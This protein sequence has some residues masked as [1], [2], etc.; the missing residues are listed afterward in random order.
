MSGR[1]FFPNAVTLE[2]HKY[3]RFSLHAAITNEHHQAFT[4]TFDQ[5]QVDARDA[6]FY[7]KMKSG[8]K[9]SDSGLTDV[10]LGGGLTV[11]VHLISADKDKSSVFKV[12]NVVVKADSLKFS[13]RDSEHDV[14]YKLLQP[15]A[16]P[17]VKQQ[18]Q[19]AI[20]GSIR[21]GLEYIDGQLVG[22]RDCMAS[23]EATEGES[24][25]KASQDLFAKKNET[26]A[27]ST[28]SVR[29]SQFKVVHN[30]C[31]S[32]SD[33]GHPAGWVN[34]TAEREDTAPKGQDWRSEAFTII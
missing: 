14:L 22:V 24:R 21:T 9:M 16:T 8:I 32:I 11:T 33:T 1:D 7:F 10:V 29:S 31:N 13:I 20:A 23:A 19:K 27:Q 4:L 17:L 6:A 3:I 2:A 12:K 5:M 34:C 15:F 30:K 26:S 25:S 18:I 28:S